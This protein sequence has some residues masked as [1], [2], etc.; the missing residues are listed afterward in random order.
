M[1][2]KKS[3][4]PKLTTACRRWRTCNPNIFRGFNLLPLSDLVP[5][6]IVT[7]TFGSTYSPLFQ[8]LFKRRLLGDSRSLLPDVTGSNAI[9]CPPKLFWLFNEEVSPLVRLGRG[10]ISRWGDGRRIAS[11]QSYWFLRLPN[12][13]V[14][15]PHSINSFWRK[16]FGFSP[17]KCSQP[18]GSQRHTVPLSWISL[19]WDSHCVSVH[20]K[21]PSGGRIHCFCHYSTEGGE[22]KANYNVFNHTNKNSV[23]YFLLSIIVPAP[24]IK[25]MSGNEVLV[26]VGRHWSIIRY[27]FVH[28]EHFDWGKFTRL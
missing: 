17:T 15:F 13:R 11:L 19:P 14:K 6:V 18:K 27:H 8:Q 25:A 23:S 5:G 7:P 9:G 4:Q 22:C 20:N 3:K 12:P 24:L 21:C 26:D 16:I 1:G 2:K 10:P 28:R